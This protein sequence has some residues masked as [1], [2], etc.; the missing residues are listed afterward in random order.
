MDESD[1][2][3]YLPD[4]INENIILCTS[5]LYTNISHK[6]G[7]EVIAFWIFNYTLL[8][9]HGVSN[10][11]SLEGLILIV[12]SDTFYFGSRYL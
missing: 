7:L 4:K 1:L 8:H 2:L 9:I 12:E 11:I 6:L 5:S 3:D 10:Q